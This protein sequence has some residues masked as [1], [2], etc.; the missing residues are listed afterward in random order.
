MKTS[1]ARNLLLGSDPELFLMHHPTGKIISGIGVVGGSKKRPHPLRRKGFAVQEDNVA[2][3]FNI[4]PA[5]TKQDFVESIR[6]AIE[7]INT[8]VSGLNYALVPI[9]SH[10]FTKEQ[11]DH[12]QAQTFGCDPDY[13]AWSGLE[14]PRPL[15]NNQNLRSAGAHIHFG[16]DYPVDEERLMVARACDLFL[17]APSVFM[18]P[19]KTRRELYGKAGAHRPKGYGMEYRTLSN[20]WLRRQELVEWVWDNAQRAFEFGIDRNNWDELGSLRQILERGINN[21]EP[22]LLQPL[23]KKYEVALV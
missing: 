9:A 20:F 2:V 5:S 7:E 13:N 14:N 8:M 22:W 10:E 11:L 21:G 23:L 17:G 16:W 1:M 4:P 19:D 12:P 18:D 6:W 15:A 3:E